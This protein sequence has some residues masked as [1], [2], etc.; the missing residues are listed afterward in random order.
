M[1]TCSSPSSRHR[2]NRRAS[3]S[4]RS[5]ACT[6]RAWR[7][8]HIV[9]DGGS[10]DGTVEILER[11]RDRIFFTTGADAGQTA[12]IN[13]GM[14]LARG[15]ILGLSELR[16][17]LLRRRG[18]RGASRRSSAT[19]RG[20]RLRRRGSHRCHDRILG[21]YPTEEWSLERLKLVCFLC[22]PAVFFRRRVMERFGTVRCAP[23]TT[24]W[25][26]NTGCAWAARRA[27]RSRPDAAGR[28]ARARADQDRRLAARG[29]RGD[30]RHAE[31]RH[32]QSAGQLALELRHAVLDATRRRRARPAAA[33]PSRGAAD[34]RRR[35]SMERIS[36]AVAA[37]GPDRV[38]PG[39]H[40]RS[41]GR[42]RSLETAS[43][44]QHRSSTSWSCRRSSA[45]G[46]YAFC[47][48]VIVAA[49]LVQ[50]RDMSVYAR[51]TRSTTWRTSSSIS[52]ASTTSSS[53][54]LRASRA[55][56]AVPAASACCCAAADRRVLS[57]AG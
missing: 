2:F 12:A 31:A 9:M 26:T 11:W 33:T 14:A 36:V 4:G 57:S 51:A 8:E 47:A 27:L 7:I 43:M 38:R 46:V 19:R 52:A 16:R 34:R 37:R 22:Q 24:A 39:S 28:V 1:T 53:A 49:E 44:R 48:S 55:A 10:T 40:L 25:T 42:T 54:A 3:S 21:A 17:R 23:A 32:R 56:P 13:T 18:G 45:L 29:A 15:E 6:G 41:P 35:V 20:R 5:R 50:R 30:Q